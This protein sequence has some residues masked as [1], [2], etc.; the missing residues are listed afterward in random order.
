[1]FLKKQVL[2]RIMGSS[3][4]IAENASRLGHADLAG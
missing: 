2:M 1:M 3:I 4:L